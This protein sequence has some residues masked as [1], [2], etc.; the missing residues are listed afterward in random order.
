LKAWQKF[1]PTAR[2]SERNFC[3]WRFFSWFLFRLRPSSW[4]FFSAKQRLYTR[5]QQLATRL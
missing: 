5:N 2:N 4:W 1:N 3:R